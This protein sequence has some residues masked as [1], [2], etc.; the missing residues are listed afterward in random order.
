MIRRFCQFYAEAAVFAVSI[1]VGIEFLE[2]GYYDK[3]RKV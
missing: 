2:K 3:R 1:S